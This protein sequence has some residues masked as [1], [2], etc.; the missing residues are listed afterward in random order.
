MRNPIA[1][2]AGI[3]ALLIAIPQSLFAAPKPISRQ[4]VQIAVWHDGTRDKL[5]LVGRV[6]REAQRKYPNLVVTVRAM[7]SAGT[8]RQLEQWCMPAD[9]AVPDVII[10]PDIWLPTF[11]H[12]LAPVDDALTPR[13]L[14]AYP[15]SVRARLRHAGALYGVPWTAECGGLFYRTDL[16]ERAGVLPPRTWEEVAIAARRCHSPP[17]VYGLGLPGVRDDGGARLLLQ[18]LWS[19]GADLP[20]IEEP[21][22]LAPEALHTV[23]ETYRELHTVAEPEVL[24]WDQPGL[25]GF[26]A[27][28][29]LAMLVADSSFKQYLAARAEDLPYGVAALPSGTRAAGYVSVNVACILK[30]GRHREAAEKLLKALT[31]EGAAE[32]LLRLGGVPV[33][34]AVIRKHRLEPEYAAYVGTV[35]QA[36]GL[37]A[38]RWES[39]EAVL[40]EGLFYLLTGRATV[41]QAADRIRRLFV[42]GESIE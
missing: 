41:P 21:E 8:Y 12:A 36:R 7:P 6:T 16:F 30:R 2:I 9:A 31:S 34:D 28:G 15:E 22:A 13:E 4:E 19:H 40:S 3:T 39:A 14:R 20:P 29:R 18:L 32:A 1:L 11:A 35:N 38:Q 37:P 26:F 24:S 42:Q 5:K 25:E 23:L 17:D 10:V 33:H 27:D